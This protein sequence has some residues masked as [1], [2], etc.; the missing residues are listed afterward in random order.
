M[1]ADAAGDDTQGQLPATVVLILDP[2][3]TIAVVIEDETARWCERETGAPF[4]LGLE[5]RQAAVVDGVLQARVLACAAIAEVA[6]GGDRRHCQRMHLRRGDESE[7]LA[8]TRIRLRIAM[9]GTHAATGANVVASQCAVAIEYRNES[10][11]L[12]QHVD[13]VARRDREADLELARQ[14]RLAIQR[15]VF[16][17]AV[18][19][20][21]RVEPGLV[22][23]AR[24]RQ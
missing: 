15:L 9:G 1:I 2:A 11:I 16:L 4:D 3:E 20:R 22:P 5:P 10:E 24:F 8:Q 13:V 12:R 19:A 23:G 21:R 14:I 18:A 6:L 17:A 7:H